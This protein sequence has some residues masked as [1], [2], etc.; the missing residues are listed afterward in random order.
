MTSPPTVAVVVA[1]RNRRAMLPGF[2]D[3]L[4]RDPA[5]S[6]LLVVLDGDVDGSADCLES[7]RAG[8][9]ALR[10]VLTEHRGHLGALELGV[11]EARAD[12]VLLMDDD[13]EAGPALATGHARRHAAG[14]GLVVMGYMP[15]RRHDGASPAT[16]LYAAE[17]EAHCRRLESG[18]VPVLGGLWLGNVSARRADLVR[19][20]IASDGF[21]AFWHSDLDLG[22]RLEEGGLRGVFD[23]TLVAS[24]LHARTAEAFLRDARARGRSAWLLEQAYPERF[25]AARTV[26]MLDDLGLPVRQAVSFLGRGRRA[27]R[28]GRFLMAAGGAVE[29]LGWPAGSLRAAKLARRVEI[30]AGYR[31]ARA[32]PP[33]SASP[34]ASQ[35]APPAP[36]A[37]D[38][39]PAAT[40]RA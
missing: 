7:L 11:A 31:T 22:L 30:V 27:D 24:H 21:A 13:V 12:V 29:R 4:A 36:S 32:A 16:R 8:Y 39:S 15:V 18:E 28:A 6:E 5:V 38:R 14:D 10:P 20:G 17:Y 40:N 37:G 26:P 1:S 19:I 25:D 34:A 2:V 3:A 23:R 33:G 35:A 9:P